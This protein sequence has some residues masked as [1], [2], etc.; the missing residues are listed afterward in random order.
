MN[1]TIT[2]YRPKKAY[3][4]YPYEYI[5]TLVWEGNDGI[6]E[7]APVSG[8]IV[9]QW[10]FSSRGYAY[11]VFCQMRLRFKR[12]QYTELQYAL[13]P[14]QLALLAACPDD[15]ALMREFGDMKDADN[16]RY[17]E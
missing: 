1:G 4:V 2:L 7:Q 14:A 11:H 12:V 5:Y 17:A 16:Q 15:K 9:H 6:T 8:V 13:S 3:T 10:T